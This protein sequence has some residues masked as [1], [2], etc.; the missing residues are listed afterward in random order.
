MKKSYFARG[1]M[2]AAALAF[3]TSMAMADKGGNKN[4]TKDQEDAEEATLAGLN[5]GA[6]PKTL[7]DCNQF[8][9]AKVF[10]ECKGKIHQ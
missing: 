4:A 7:D 2:V 3:T 6:G 9:T 10:D 8:D 1:L 5:G